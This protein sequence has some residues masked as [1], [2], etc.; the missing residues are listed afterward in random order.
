MNYQKQ[1]LENFK[2]ELAKVKEWEKAAYNRMTKYSASGDLEKANLSRKAYE[3]CRKY[4]DQLRHIIDG[5]RKRNSGLWFT[6]DA[7]KRYKKPDD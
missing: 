4:A 6:K 3:S 1:D 7:G 5:I 2:R